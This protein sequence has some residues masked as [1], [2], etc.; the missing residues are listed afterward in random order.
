[1]VSDVLCGAACYWLSD[2][3][4]QRMEGATGGDGTATAAE[5]DDA[6]DASRSMG[7]VRD[8][9]RRKRYV[10]FGAL[11]GGT[12][13]L[14]YEWVDWV[15]GDDPMRSELATVGEK[16]LID[17]AVYNPFWAALFIAYMGVAS[18]KTVEEVKGDLDRDWLELFKSNVVFWVPMNFIVY[19]VF[20]LE[21][22]VYGLYTLNVLFVCTLSLFEERK[23]SLRKSGETLSPMDVVAR[24]REEAGK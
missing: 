8:D 6:D 17:A 7:F 4:A 15:V 5:G 1:M 19:G 20:P 12:S 11:D 10:S 24:V 16:V 14:W 23:A 3:L 2:E 22:R 18:R 21:T 13:Y 9:G